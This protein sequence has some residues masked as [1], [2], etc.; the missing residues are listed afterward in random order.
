[1][2]QRSA[3]PVPDEQSPKRAKT[4]HNGSTNSDSDSTSHFAPD[5]LAPNTIHR[6]SSEYANSE[7]YKY[8]K[9]DKLFQDDLLVAV[10]DEILAELSFTEKETDIY[11]VSSHSSS[12]LPLVCSYFF[13]HGSIRLTSNR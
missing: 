11:K 13:Y 7:P 4:G 1:M 12:T 6:L 2:H 3:S 9:V 8:C 5:L 10:K